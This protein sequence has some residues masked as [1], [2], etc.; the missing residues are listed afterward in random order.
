MSQRFAACEVCGAERWTVRYEGVIRDGVPGQVRDG[1]AVAR[2]GGCGVDRLDEA[3]C[4]DDSMYETAAYRDKLREAATAE[5]HYAV[6]DQL[7]VFTQRVLWPASL[8]GKTVM[9]V[10][11]A[12]GSWL[13]H[14]RGVA[15]RGVAIEPAEAYHASLRERGYEVFPYADQALAAWQRKVDLAVSIQVIEHVRNPREFLASIRPLLAPGGKLVVSTPNRDDIL[16]ELLPDFRGHFYRVVHRWYFDAM[17]LTACA[18]LAGFEVSSTH[19]I[20]RFGMANA[21]GWLR[22][23]RPAGRARMPVITPLAD[24][25]WRAYLE[26]GGRADCLYMILTADDT[27]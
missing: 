6:V 27:R 2:C 12:G 18:A 9:D 15:R 17:S 23:K 25:L 19:F 3:S 20:H 26:Q 21:L 24:D 7:Q 4:L 1:A 14:V 8:R 13:D 22:D 5:G 11:A 10:G 16:M